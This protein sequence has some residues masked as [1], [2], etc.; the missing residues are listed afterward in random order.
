VTIVTPPQP[1]QEPKPQP[2]PQPQTQP[3]PQPAKQ[4]VKPYPVGVVETL[5]T[6]IIVEVPQK[7]H[8]KKRKNR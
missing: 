3:E 5:E 1:K 4:V 7:E 8:H 6:G 2:Q